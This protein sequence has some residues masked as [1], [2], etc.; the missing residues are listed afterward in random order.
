MPECGR[1]HPNVPIPVKEKVVE[2]KVVPS[3][4]IKVPSTWNEIRQILDYRIPI[5]IVFSIA[6]NV[7]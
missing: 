4:Y 7:A 2:K 1:M 6:L 3:G 5:I